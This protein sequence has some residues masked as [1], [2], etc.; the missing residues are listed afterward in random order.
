MATYRRGWDVLR[1]ERFARMNALG[2]VAADA[3]L[4]LSLVPVEKDDASANGFSGKPNPAWDS[5]PADRRE[6]LARQAR[7]IDDCGQICWPF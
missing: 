1:A 2:L 3:V 5:L 6:D 4:P 7:L